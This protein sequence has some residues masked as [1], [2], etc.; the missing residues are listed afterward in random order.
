MKALVCLTELN[1]LSSVTCRG[2]HLALLNGEVPILLP[3]GRAHRTSYST[4]KRCSTQTLRLNIIVQLE[5]H[6][7]FA[8]IGSVMKQ[9]L[10]QK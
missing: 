6:P 10:S 5:L 1:P 8:I 4:P 2:A 7:G 9:Q 3:Q